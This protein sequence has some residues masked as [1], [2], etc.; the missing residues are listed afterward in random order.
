MT[1]P[2][3]TAHLEPIAHEL[4]VFAPGDGYGDPYEFGCLARWISPTIV[5]LRLCDDP[6]ATSMWRSIRDVLAAAGAEEV[7]LRRRGQIR[8]FRIS[9]YSK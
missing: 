4:R 5:E 7:W 9:D 8:K 3:W 2:T 6:P 1:K